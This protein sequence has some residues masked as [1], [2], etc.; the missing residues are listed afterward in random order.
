MNKIISKATLF[1]LSAS[2]LLMTSCAAPAKTNPAAEPPTEPS[3]SSETAEVISAEAYTQSVDTWMERVNE[4]SEAARSLDQLDEAALA[5]YTKETVS[6]Y[7]E[8]I[9]TEA[10]DEFSEAHQKLC[11]GSEQMIKYLNA[12]TEFFAITDTAEYEA[13][14]WELFTLSGVAQ[15]NIE[16]GFKMIQADIAQ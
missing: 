6:I 11:E 15:A 1:A 7:Q 4:S 9:E 16:D 13:A 14:R 2:M 5:E 8:M 12:L 3:Q 10:P